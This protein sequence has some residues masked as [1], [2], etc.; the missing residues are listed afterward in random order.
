MADGLAG[1]RWQDGGVEDHAFIRALRTGDRDAFDQLVEREMRSVYQAS[2]R[3]LG[4]PDDAEDVTQEAFVAAYRSI[5]TFR[6]EGTA[7]A[8]L[9]RIAS[10]LAFR[11]LAQR[12]PTA[13]LEGVSDAVVASSEGEPTRLVVRAETEQSVRLAVSALSDPYREVVALRFF[14]DLALAEIADVTGRPLG[15]VKTQ[16]RRGLERLRPGLAVEQV[17]R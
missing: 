2:L 12:R 17:E 14:G 4:R 13:P 11:R 16:L 10:R 5:R 6:G 1:T 3:I 8:W 9:I 15:T 7:R